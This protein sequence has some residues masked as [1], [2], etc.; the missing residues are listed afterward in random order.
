MLDKIYKSAQCEKEKLEIE[1]AA[2]AES[3][4]INP[5][6]YWGT[7]EKFIEKYI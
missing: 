2:H 3:C 1:E 4:N 5:E 6:K 7:I